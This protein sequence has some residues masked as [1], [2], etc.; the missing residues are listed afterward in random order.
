VEKRPFGR[1]LTTHPGVGVL[2]E[3]AFELV[4]GTPK[5]FGCWMWSQGSEYGQFDKLG[6]HAGEPAPPHGVQ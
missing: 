4:I 6:S 2:T 3:L 1:R 5:R